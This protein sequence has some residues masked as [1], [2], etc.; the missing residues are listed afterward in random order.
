MSRL[1]AGRVNIERRPYDAGAWEA[2]VSAH[3]EAEPFH[4]AA[5]LDYLNVAFG[6]EPVVATVRLD[7]RAVGHIV[8]A[9]VR[10]YRVRI[11][12][13]PLRG[14]GTEYLGFLLDP[15]IDRRLVADAL[16]PF[17]FHDLGC[18][19]V[20]LGDSALTVDA[21]AGSAY[22]L[23]PGITWVVDL[24]PDE[25]AILGTMRQTTRNYVRQAERKGVMVEVAT[26]PEFADDY[27]T[28]LTE[29]FGRQGLAPTYGVDRV[30]T[31]LATVGPSG[32]L[33]CLRVRDPQGRSIATGIF[34]GRNQ[35][36]VLWGA[37][38]RRDDAGHHPNEAMHWEAMRYWRARGATVYDLGGA[39]DYKAKF[40]AT[41]APTPRFVASRYAVLDTGRS[42]VRRLFRARQVVAARRRSGH[43]P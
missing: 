12:G 23:E 18:L 15:G 43:A 30:R 28:Q 16:L 11:L 1:T 42:V 26:D 19:H 9:V 35:R 17:A 3:P 2:V 29:V 27:H 6:A 21:M 14:W 40:G 4:G 39:G 38:F 31:L 5:W 7:G 24:R 33:L 20:E 13:S 41:V 22:R 10:S 36:A 34:V 37:A 8:G 25:S 32:A